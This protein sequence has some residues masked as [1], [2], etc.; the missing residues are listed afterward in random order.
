MP[1][2]CS[3]SGSIFPNIAVSTRDDCAL[4]WHGTM[5]IRMRLHPTI[6]MLIA[7]LRGQQ[8]MENRSEFVVDLLNTLRAGRFSPQA[9]GSFLVSSWVR[10]LATARA[11]PML[12][13]S[14]R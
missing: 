8:H 4:Q 10:A 13:R 7:Y 3:P 2:T 5:K 9:W 14:W 1:H 11:N 6:I 12:V